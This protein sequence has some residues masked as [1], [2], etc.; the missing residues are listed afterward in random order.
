MSSHSIW[1]ADHVLV[2]LAFLLFPSS[3]S[4]ELATVI[5]FSFFQVFPL[6]SVAPLP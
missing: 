4:L 5:L 1:K 6:L 3:Y 2:Q